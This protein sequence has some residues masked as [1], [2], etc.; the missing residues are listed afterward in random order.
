M[1]SILLATIQ[2][3]VLELHVISW[4]HTKAEKSGTLEA[5]FGRDFNLIRRKC[6]LNLLGIIKIVLRNHMRRWTNQPSQ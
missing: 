4:M 3:A 5:E 1:V 2:N 6:L